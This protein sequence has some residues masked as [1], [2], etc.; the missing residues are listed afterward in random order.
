MT[1]RGREDEEDETHDRDNSEEPP[2][3]L[4]QEVPQVDGTLLP[5]DTMDP[6]TRESPPPGILTELEV[7]G[8][9]SKVPST[10]GLHLSVDHEE[11]SMHSED[12]A[13]DDRVLE[14]E[15]SEV[16]SDSNAVCDGEVPVVPESFSVV[17]DDA[18]SEMVRSVANEL[19]AV[20]ER[21]SVSNGL[22]VP[23]H[24]RQN[25]LSRTRRGGTNMWRIQS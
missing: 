14:V 3:P 7:L 20:T 15:S 2:P 19:H 21:L 16:V 10:L 4:L 6:T 17:E 25:R 9:R 12:G 8:E 11:R 18:L 22:L 1:E 5:D 13:M 24:T 23:V